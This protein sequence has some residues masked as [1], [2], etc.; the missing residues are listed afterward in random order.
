M[1]GSDS[2]FALTYLFLFLTGKPLK[3][4]MLFT[5]ISQLWTQS[6]LGEKCPHTLHCPTQVQNSLPEFYLFIYFTNSDNIKTGKA[7]LVQIKCLL[8]AFK[9][10]IQYIQS[11]YRKQNLLSY[12]A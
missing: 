4:D 5:D 10:H 2:P 12:K 7:A 1:K 8:R 3:T 6:G 11:V 9:D